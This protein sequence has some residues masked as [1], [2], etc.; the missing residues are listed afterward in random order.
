M[1]FCLLQVNTELKP[2]DFTANVEENTLHNYL[3]TTGVP[4]VLCML[5]SGETKL[6]CTPLTLMLIMIQTSTA[7]VG[8][9]IKHALRF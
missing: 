2:G 5:L 6:V 9:Y 3:E 8:S 1:A 7:Q 4:V